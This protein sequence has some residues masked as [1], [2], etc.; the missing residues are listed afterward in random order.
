MY[1]PRAVHLTSWPGDLIRHYVSPLGYFN[2]FHS[3]GG[4][5]KGI[6]MENDLLP[7]CNH[8]YDEDCERC[9]L[10]AFL[11]IQQYT[12]DEPNELVDIYDVMSD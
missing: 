9:V 10:N 6:I 11:V 1:V 4:L 7:L 8:K 5:K 2:N 12:D 3:P